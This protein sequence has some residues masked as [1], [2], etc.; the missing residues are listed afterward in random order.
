[1]DHFWGR[2]PCTYYDCEMV[3]VEKLKNKFKGIL[4]EE[5][6]E[7]AMKIYHVAIAVKN[8]YD[9]LNMYKRTYGW[10]AIKIET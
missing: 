4:R 3:G 8:I 6:Y 7:M 2:G 1:M 5:R 10:E 9:V